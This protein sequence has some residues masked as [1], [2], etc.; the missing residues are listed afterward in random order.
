MRCG[1]IAKAVWNL[2][3]LGTRAAMVGPESGRWNR[4]IGVSLGGAYP[5]A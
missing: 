5:D 2:C 3:S 4:V 1:R